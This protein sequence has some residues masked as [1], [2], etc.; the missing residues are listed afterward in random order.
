MKHIIVLLL[1][2]FGVVASPLLSACTM[3]Y[4]LMG[5]Q[6]CTTISPTPGQP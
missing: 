5:D 4:P 2:L 6:T 3:V 1:L